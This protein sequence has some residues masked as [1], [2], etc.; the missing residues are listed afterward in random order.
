MRPTRERNTPIP[1]THRTE[2]RQERRNQD[3]EMDDTTLINLIGCWTTTTTPTKKKARPSM[4][5]PH[6]ILRRRRGRNEENEETQRNLHLVPGLFLQRLV[7]E[8]ERVLDQTQGYSFDGGVME[9][10]TLAQIGNANNLL[11]Q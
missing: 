2:R 9:Q 1:A 3:G 11:R 8:V 10:Q 6:N 7:Q 5:P 4:P